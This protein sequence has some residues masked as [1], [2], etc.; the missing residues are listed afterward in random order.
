MT[1]RSAGQA[2]L[3]PKCGSAM[4]SYERNGIVVD[5]CT[6]C[7]GVLLDRGEL[8]RLVDAESAFMETAQHGRPGDDDD[9]RSGR[10]HDDDDPRR[11]SRD[12][13]SGRPGRRRGGFL[14]NILEGLGGD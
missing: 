13:G 1:E 10:G 4:H 3:C 8:E 14:G 2:L 6:G 7:R 5:Q 12:Y 9:E 11:D